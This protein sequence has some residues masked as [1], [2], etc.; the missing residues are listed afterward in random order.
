MNATDS[1]ALLLP[2][3]VCLS[4]GL[5]GCLIGS[6]T[7]T[8]NSGQFVSENTLAQIQPGKDKSYVVALA[9][10]P[11]SKVA[12]DASTEIWKWSYS[13]EV[14][15]SGHVILLANSD[16]QTETRHTTFVEFN[17]SKVVKAWTD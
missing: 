13:Q 16:T 14:N 17:N 10:E 7:R 3:V 8:E 15:S 5:S 1:R 6:H 4:I 12:V 11:T 9:G 2:A